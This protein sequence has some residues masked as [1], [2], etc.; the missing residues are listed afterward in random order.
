MILR[1]L[2][3]VLR[4]NAHRGDAAQDHRSGRRAR[5]RRDPPLRRGR[6]RHRRG[7]DDALP[8]PRERGRRSAARTRSRWPRIGSRTWAAQCHVSA[9]SSRR[10]RVPLDARA[11]PRRCSSAR[12]CSSTRAP[13]AS[14]TRSAACGVVRTTISK[15]LREWLT[16]LRD[17]G[18]FGMMMG[19]KEHVPIVN[20]AFTPTPKR[21]RTGRS[22]TGSTIEAEA[23]GRT[24]HLRRRRT[25]VRATRCTSRTSRPRG[26]CWVGARTGG[27]V[28]RPRAAEIR[29]RAVAS[30]RRRR[31]ALRG[32]RAA[33]RMRRCSPTSKRWAAARL[34]DRYAQR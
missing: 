33:P 25:R 19:N 20:A 28:S 6:A 17:I 34:R 11:A 31:R 8:D 24:R 10:H 9:T 26:S 21:S 27:R 16:E 7:F 14:G 4:P 12:R 2:E 5:R 18:Y 15:G 23:A 22:S 32:D 30:D 29:A 13:R 1:D 3:A